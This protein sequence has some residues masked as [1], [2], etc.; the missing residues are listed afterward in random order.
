MIQISNIFNWRNSFKLKAKHPMKSHNNC[1][2]SCT[3]PPITIR[4]SLPPMFSWSHVLW[5]GMMDHPQHLVEGMACDYY[6]ECGTMPPCFGAP[7]IAK[8]LFHTHKSPLV[9]LIPQ[10]PRM[11][12]MS[13]YN[14]IPPFHKHNWSNKRCNMWKNKWSEWV[15]LVKMSLFY[16]GQIKNPCKAI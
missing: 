8:F 11:H 10:I 9:C 2:A 5:V 4:Q 6:V 13:C 12:N 16:Q 3:S 1:C 15:W 7:Y 14:I